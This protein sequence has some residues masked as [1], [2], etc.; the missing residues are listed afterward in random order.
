[1]PTRKH[2]AC[3]YVYINV[4][5]YAYYVLMCMYV[6]AYACMYV[7]MYVSI[8]QYSFIWWHDIKTD[9]NAISIYIAGLECSGVSCW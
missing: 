7:C 4:R 1:M 2:Y 3:V 5:M 6:S 8:N 9:I